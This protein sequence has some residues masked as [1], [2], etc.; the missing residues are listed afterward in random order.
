MAR[1][2]SIALAAAAVCVAA[3]V[4]G[5]VTHWSV[6]V[7]GAARVVADTTTTTAPTST[8]TLPAGEGPWAAPLPAGQWARVDRSAR[9]HDY[10]AI[11]LPVPLGTPVYAVH[12][13]VA[14][15]VANDRC[16]TGVTVDDGEVR[17]VYCHGT[18]R[19]VDDGDR[20]PAGRLLLDA[21]ATGRASGPHLHL[22][23][24]V[25]GEARCPQ[26]LLDALYRTSAGVDP[27]A[28]PSSG[29]TT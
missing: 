24:W 5:N 7:P 4:D 29:C 2:R 13:G 28:L 23:I 8:T 19:H 9:H 25:A 26:P 22:G 10:P 20:V 18:G 14:H 11:D 15:H 1:A 16:G 27:A 6:P 12:G 21:G 17:W 3:A